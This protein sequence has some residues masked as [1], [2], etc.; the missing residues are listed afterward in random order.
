MQVLEISREISYTP[1]S[2]LPHPCPPLIRSFGL[3]LTVTKET[4]PGRENMFCF[5]VYV[6]V[7]EDQRIFV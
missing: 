7:G 6:G 4:G 2:Y 5:S 3:S 1:S